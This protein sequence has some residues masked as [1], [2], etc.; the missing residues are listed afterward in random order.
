VSLSCSLHIG[1][2]FLEVERKEKERERKKKKEEE[3]GVN[4][5][6]KESVV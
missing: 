4:D 3:S 5:K 6:R 1:D 2:T